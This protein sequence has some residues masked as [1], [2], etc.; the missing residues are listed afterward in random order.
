MG[1]ERGG[2]VGTAGGV[3]P[4]VCAHEHPVAID[5]ER[6]DHVGDELGQVGGWVCQAGGD[7]VGDQFAALRVEGEEQ[8]VE[9]VK[10]GVER[11]TG[12]AGRLAHLLDARPSEPSRSED[13]ERGV[14]KS[15]AGFGSTAGHPRGRPLGSS[16]SLRGLAGPCSLPC[17]FRCHH[18]PSLSIR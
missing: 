1:D 14:E 18:T 3:E 2:D 8:L 9:G 17:A 13:T 16:Q 12:V 5:H 15:G 11:A 7:A 10:V 6:P 4:K